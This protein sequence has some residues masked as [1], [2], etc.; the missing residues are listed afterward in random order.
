MKE[1]DPILIEVMKNELISIGEEMGIT[2]KRTARSLAA[3][4]GDFSTS[5]VD[6]EGRI[7]AQG[8]AIGLQGSGFSE[9]QHSTLASLFMTLPR[10]SGV[11]CRSAHRLDSLTLATR[12]DAVARHSDP[13]IEPFPYSRTRQC[14]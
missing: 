1:L 13:C 6:E 11:V 4:T 12:T 14:L 3:Q 9:N 8:F 5:I 2:L 7:L 10:A